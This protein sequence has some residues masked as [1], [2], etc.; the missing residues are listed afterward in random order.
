MIV[1]MPVLQHIPAECLDVFSS[2]MMSKQT[3][4]V[5]Q[6]QDLVDLVAGIVCLARLL[7]QAQVDQ[8]IRIIKWKVID[9]QAGD[10]LHGSVDFL[11]SRGIPCVP[12]TILM[13]ERGDER[14]GGVSRLSI[15]CFV[16]PI[17]HS[18]QREKK[19]QVAEMASRAPR[20]GPVESG[21]EAVDVTLCCWNV[22]GEVLWK[23]AVQEQCTIGLSGFRADVSAVA[24]IVNFSLFQVRQNMAHESSSCDEGITEGSI[25]LLKRE[26][27]INSGLDSGRFRLSKQGKELERKD[28]SG[29]VG[30]LLV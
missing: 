11:A 22:G 7:C 6:H 29:K 16:D 13:L 23:N 14:A 1:G 5:A 27:S 20:K 18:Q 17:R 26:N 30:C 2:V 9:N 24:Q 19:H 3:I 10:H 12:R 28:A 25:R 21:E 8:F 15:H 4:A